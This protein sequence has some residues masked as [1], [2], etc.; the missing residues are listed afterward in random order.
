MPSNASDM[1]ATDVL[2]SLELAY[3]QRRPGDRVLLREFP[4]ACSGRGRIDGL[5]IEF[6]SNRSAARI[7]YE[8]KV[9]RR[10][11]EREV[12]NPDKRHRAMAIADA[13]Y[14]VTPIGLVRDH[15]IP[16][17]CGLLWVDGSRAP[18][19]AK[20]APM[21]AAPAPDWPIIQAMIRR[22]YAHG[23]EDAAKRSPIAA[24]DPAFEV[25]YLLAYYSIL[26]STDGPEFV[27]EADRHLGDL[28]RALSQHGRKDDS[29][30][31]KELRGW[32]KG[33]VKKLAEVRSEN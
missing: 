2:N 1:T 10:D 9:N 30:R 18:I 24:W 21:N 20:S 15:E 19:I 6:R 31:F 17:G 5:L 33:E 16:D 8:V 11:F 29:G 25:A 23:Q 4:L 22:A 3:C 13:F 28:E 27:Q 14:F 7:A 26:L 12:K 32:M